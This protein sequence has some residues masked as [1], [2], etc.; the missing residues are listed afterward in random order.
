MVVIG[1]THRTERMIIIC[2]TLFCGVFLLI[3]HFDHSDRKKPV[4]LRSINI[5]NALDSPRG[6]SWGV[7]MKTAYFPAIKKAGFNAVRIPVRFSDYAKDNPNYQLDPAFMKKLDGDIDDA[8]QQHLTV[9]LDFHHFNELMEDPPRYHQCFLS[10]WNQL[11]HRYQNQP[12]Q[13]MFEILNEP[14]DRLSGELWNRYMA[15]AV[16]VIRKTNPNRTLI[17]G[18]DHFYALDRLKELRLPKDRHLIVSFHYYEP[19]TFTFQSNPYLGFTQARDVTWQGTPQETRRIHQQFT[20]VR[21][22]A[23]RHHVP[24]YLGEFGANK[25]APDDSRLRWTAAVRREAEKEG[26]SWGYWELASWFGIY[27]SKTGE[28]DKPML[29]ALLPAK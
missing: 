24:V 1:L 8:L 26:F 12:D 23:E 6:T 7:T 29:Q 2:L 13:L 15:D 19:N 14:T 25:D 16:S 5:G 3:I 27:N 22:W 11:A 17:V 9:I 4:A 21:R 20:K 18:P 10:I 28:W